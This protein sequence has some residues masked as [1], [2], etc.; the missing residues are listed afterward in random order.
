MPEEQRA[1]E[2]HHDELLNKLVRKVLHRTVD[3][4]RS[5]VGGYDLDSFGETNLQLRELCANSGNRA[6]RILAR[7]KDVDAA[8]NL[9]FAVQLSHS[10]AH[11][12]PQLNRCLITESYRDA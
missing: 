11:F 5:V 6:P 2:R 7:A 8:G 4:L 10:A 3:Q 12:R 1:N 9:P